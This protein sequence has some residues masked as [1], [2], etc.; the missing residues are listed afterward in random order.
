MKALFACEVC[1]TVV[2]ALATTSGTAA[3]EPPRPTVLDPHPEPGWRQ[4]RCRAIADVDYDPRGSTIVRR[5]GGPLGRV[6]L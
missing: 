4:R 3:I 2:L 5:C 1:G 6:E